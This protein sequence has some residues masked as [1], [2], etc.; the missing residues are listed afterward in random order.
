MSE[1][2]Y[3]RQAAEVARAL[4]N[5]ANNEEAIENFESYLSYCFGAWVE[6]YA[7]D[8]DGIAAELLSFSVI[9]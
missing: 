3:T 5:F 1:R 4:R 8:P 7:S 9:Q 2:I 6:K